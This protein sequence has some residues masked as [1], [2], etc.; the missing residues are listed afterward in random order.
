MGAHERKQAEMQSREL[1]A[2]SR[3]LLDQI[4]TTTDAEV[5]RRLAER[6]FELAQRAEQLE[7][8]EQS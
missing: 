1:R 7:R 6:A 2:A 5:R 3:H 8:D 4:K